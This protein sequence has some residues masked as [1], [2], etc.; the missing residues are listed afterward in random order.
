MNV[1]LVQ[2]ARIALLNGWSVADDGSCLRKLGDCSHGWCAKWESIEIDGKTI[3]VP[4]YLEQRLTELGVISKARIFT[5]RRVETV[6]TEIDVIDFDGDEARA[7]IRATVG[8][9]LLQKEHVIALRNYDDG[10]KS[11]TTLAFVNL[12]T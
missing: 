5:F 9:D 12:P 3:K 8:P 4:H 11:E 6:V 1:P 10:R 7:L 2:L